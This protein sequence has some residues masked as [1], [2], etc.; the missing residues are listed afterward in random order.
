MFIIGLQAILRAWFINILKNYLCTKFHVPI[1]SGSLVIAI[2]PK[3]AMLYIK[4][5]ILTKLHNFQDPLA[6]IISVH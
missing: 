6:S 3:A 2:I 5:L 1:S 4:N